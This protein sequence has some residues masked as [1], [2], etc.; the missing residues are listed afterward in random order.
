MNDIIIRAKKI[1]KQYYINPGKFRYGNLRDFLG[2]MLKQPFYFGRKKVHQPKMFKKQII[3]ALK[4]VSF[5]VKRG[6][7]VGIIGRNGSGKTTLLKILSRITKPTTG[8][9]EIYGRVG[10]LLEVGTGFHEELTGRDNI[11]LNGAILGMNKR[12]IHRKFEE[13]VEFAEIKEF[14][15]T[16]VKYYSSGM[17]VRL[18]FAIAAHLQSEI[19]LIDEVLAVGDIFFQKKCFKKI[20]DISQEGRTILF[21]SHNMQAVESLCSRGILIDNGRIIADSSPSDA[22]NCYLKNFFM[23]EPPL[24]LKERKDRRGSGR[25]K[26]VTISFYDQKGSRSNF[27]KS[28]EGCCIEFEYEATENIRKASIAFNV[29]DASSQYLFR[30]SSEDTGQ[31]FEIIPRHAYFR[32]SIPKLPLV[33]GRYRITTFLTSGGIEEDYVEGAAMFT[34]EGGDFFGSGKISLHSPV[35]LDHSWSLREG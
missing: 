34:V 26:I 14:L 7:V 3:L 27:L 17:Y 12:E 16:P 15:N 1:S 10:S 5:Q 21:V 24:N 28:G 4:D 23:A 31:D 13:I 19:L 20:S 32:C 33:P 22:V 11:Y 6:E 30:P 9:A 18:A 2:E 25:I 35:I 8:C 29:R